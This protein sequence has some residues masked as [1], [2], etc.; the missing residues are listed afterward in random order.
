MARP[1]PEYSKNQVAR[2]GTI[3]TLGPG[4]LEQWLWAFDVLSNWRACHGYPINTFQSTLR[5][6]LKKIDR[7]ALVAQRLKRMPSIINKLRR[8]PAMD[9]S[10]M[11]DIGGL[12][13][14]VAS[15][16]ELKALYRNYKDSRFTHTLVSE[17]N[18]VDSPKTSGYRGIHM[19]YRYKLKELPHMTV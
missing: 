11:Q 3:L 10:R 17:F 16:E 5:D 19:V 15:I 8:Y 9:L 14:V 4:D 6:K 13:A 1:I 2:A 18:Y 12:R 7:D